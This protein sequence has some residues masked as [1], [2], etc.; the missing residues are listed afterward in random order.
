MDKD[1]GKIIRFPR[2]KERLLEKG[3]EELQAKRY[4]E[5]L[6]LLQEAY[7][8]DSSDSEVELGIV[9]CL[10]ELGEIAQAKERC[11][12]MLQEGKGDY[13]EILQVYLSILIHLQ[14]YGEVVTTINA[15]L[16]ESDLSS[17]LRQNL[18]NLLHFSEKMSQ[19]MPIPPKRNEEIKELVRPLIESNEIVKHM[20]VIKQL[21]KEDIIPVLPVLKQVLADEKSSP[22]TKTM[23]L[24][25]LISKRIADRI[26]I[27]KF[28][29]TLTIIPTEL[30]ENIQSRFAKEVLGIVE[31]HI[32]TYNPSLYDIAESIWLRYLYVLYPFI[33]EKYTRKEWAAAL[34][35]IA[36]RYQGMEI[37][38]TEIEH[39]YGID[40]EEIS[41]PCKLLWEIEE[42]S[43]FGI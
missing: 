7:G 11:Q 12:K 37:N 13:F 17:Q 30:D 43:Q 19:Q 14:H 35:V 39:L 8:M 26:I 20:A 27:K 34:H 9:I 28:G 1:K 23:I 6:H 42:I 22:L 25:L 2:L 31:E 21:E 3:L 4:K 16:E 32:Y 29:N 38:K 41:V 18:M 15:V 36:C 24:R 33:P 40:Y 10:F 5:A